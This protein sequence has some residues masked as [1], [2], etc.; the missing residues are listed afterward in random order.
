MRGNYDSPTDPV[1]YQA[2]RPEP[3]PGPPSPVDGWY[4]PYPPRY[5]D[6]IGEER[7]AGLR[8]LSKLTWRAT[9]LS[10]VATVGFAALFAHTAHSYAA[11]TTATLKHTAK[12]TTSPSPTPT[13][14]K[15]KHHHHH[16]AAAAAAAPGGASA[17]AGAPAPAPAPPTTAPAPP[18]SSAPPPTSSGG[19]SGGG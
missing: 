10:A 8:R 11:S 17:A 18:P 15:K 7:S 14:T 4:P 19:S 9:Q 13:K 2:R 1:A 5:Y 12:P 6:P 16:H 3:A